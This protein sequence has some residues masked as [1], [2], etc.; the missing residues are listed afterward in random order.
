[1]GTIIEINYGNI[2]GALALLFVLSIVYDRFVVE[3]IETRDPPLG[4]TAFEVV[5]GV[6]YT[7]VISSIVLGLEAAFV[8]SMLFVASGIPMIL[9]SHNRHMARDD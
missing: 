8:M 5:G 3:R 6:G 7:I 2:P 9:G 1:L 4:V